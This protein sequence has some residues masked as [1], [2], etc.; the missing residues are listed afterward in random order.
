MMITLT[1][2]MHKVLDMFPDAIVEE[3]IDGQIV[4]ATGFTIDE[5]QKLIPLEEEDDQWD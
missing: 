3:D 4:V 1:D 5:D 2:L